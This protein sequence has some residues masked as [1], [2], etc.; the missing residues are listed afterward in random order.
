MKG[1][2]LEMRGITKTFGPVKALSDVSITLNEN[3]ILG[4]VGENGAGKSTLMKILSGSWPANSYTGDI[5]VDGKKQNFM[6]PV[7][8]AK[9]GI[10]MIYQEISM[11][12]ELTI[13]ENIFLGRVPNKCGIVDRKAMYA[14]C[15]EY[16]KLVGLNLSPKTIVRNLSTSQQQMVAIAR[17][18]SRKPRILILDEP[19]SALTET[20]VEFLLS[21]LKRFKDMG[22]SS[23]Y[24]SHK[25][26]EVF[27]VC[28]RITTLRDGHTINTSVCYSEKE[29]TDQII[30][31]MIGR[32]LD[33]MYP[34]E[35]VPIGEEILRFE[36][37]TVK[38][39]IEGKN[40]VDRASM[41]VHAG[42]IVALAG[43]VG[44]GRSETVN[45]LFGA[46]KKVS[47][48]VW[49]DGK[50]VRINN[51]RDAIDAGL[52]LVTEDR[53]A[54]GFIKEFNIRQ[55]IS[56]ASV[57]QLAKGIIFDRKKEKEI[58]NK[59]MK[60]ISIKAPS[61]ETMVTKLSGGN[62]QKVVLAKWLC[63][64]LKVLILD[65]PTRGV[66]V[67]AKAQ[68]YEI[69]TD[70]VKRGIGIIMISSELPE[71]MAMCDR[72][73]VMAEGRITA[74]LKGDEITE[75]NMMKNATR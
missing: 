32:K 45:A 5:Y 27:T 57:D 65:E 73:Y 6:S 13:A 39:P 55:N 44:A 75:A 2:I 21:S 8:S 43:L 50:P 59:Q 52:G 46:L 69:M 16:L 54:T 22:I 67:G 37:I 9:A 63:K 62:Q 1:P 7:D 14:Q 28:D 20:E 36:N 34:K 23:I 38:G 71:L 12:P 72:M 56:V 29:Q 25:L 48:N 51:P 49:V 70:M 42:E 40:I 17:A 68:I 74:E 4:L 31:E 35:I 60:D 64:D 30:E 53:R 19:T 58:A 41:V 66:D 11:H 15:E 61:I 24:I 47:G 33:V 18:L 10:E 26:T 3:E